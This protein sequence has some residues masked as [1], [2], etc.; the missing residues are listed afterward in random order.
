MEIIS[1]SIGRYVMRTSNWDY[2]LIEVRHPL[3]AVEVVFISEYLPL[4]RR[5]RSLV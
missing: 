3:D 2:A 4:F 5:N 1:C